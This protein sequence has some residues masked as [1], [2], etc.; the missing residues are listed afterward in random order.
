M[1]LPSTSGTPNKA[2]VVELDMWTNI[3]VSYRPRIN[4][5]TLGQ[6]QE[7][8]NDKIRIEYIKQQTS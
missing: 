4:C 8:N 1:H 7:E 3:S 6:K 5:K 2:T